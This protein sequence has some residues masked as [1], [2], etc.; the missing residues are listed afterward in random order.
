MEELEEEIL[1]R[2]P[3]HEPA[4]VCKRWRRLVSGP[5]FRRRFRELHH[6][7]PMLG[8]LCN[9]MEEGNLSCFLHSVAAFRAPDADLGGYRA[10]DARHGRDE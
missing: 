9:S 5:G 8:L 4:L 7:P 6:T 1:L 3:P 2:F 10:L